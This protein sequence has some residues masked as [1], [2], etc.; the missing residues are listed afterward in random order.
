MPARTLNPIVRDLAAE[1]LALSAALDG[2][3]AIQWASAPI[4]KPKDDT[5]ERAK[6]GHGDPTFDTVAD[7]RRLG[8]REAVKSGLDELERAIAAVRQA[9]GAVEFAVARYYGDDTTRR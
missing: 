1:S 4:A 2:A 9:R 5:T 6:G 8:V 7:D 3:S